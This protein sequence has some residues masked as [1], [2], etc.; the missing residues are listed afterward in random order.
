MKTEA[1]QFYYLTTDDLLN[2]YS[3]HKYYWGQVYLEESDYVY[4]W[5]PQLGFKG[6]VNVEIDTGKDAGDFLWNS[7]NLLIVSQRVLDVWEGSVRIETYDVA[8]SG[9]KTE[10][11]YKGVICMGRADG[12]DPVRSKARYMQIDKKRPPSLMG[13]EGFYFDHSTWD[14]SAL[15]V[16]PDFP[17]YYIA[18]SALMNRMKKAGLTNIDFLPLEMLRF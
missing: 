14:G 13:M 6:V 17:R 2:T 15:F 3:R 1:Q 12:F 8:V 18:T 11:E 10:H 5:D 7:H 4:L 9:L 16:L